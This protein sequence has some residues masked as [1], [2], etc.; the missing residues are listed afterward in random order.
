MLEY[1]ATERP[2]RHVQCCR[3]ASKKAVA[4]HEMKFQENPRGWN[5]QDL[6]WTRSRKGM[7]NSSSQG[8]CSDFRLWSPGGAAG[9]KVAAAGFFGQTE[10]EVPARC[11]NGAFYQAVATYEFRAQ[12]WKLKSLAG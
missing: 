11:P 1:G 9:L 2:R 7:K 3:N 8:W 4:S 12:K 6:G 5:W 10:F